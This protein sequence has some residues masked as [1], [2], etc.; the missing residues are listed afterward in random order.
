MSYFSTINHNLAIISYISWRLFVSFHCEEVG[1]TGL[2]LKKDVTMI[3]TILIVIL[4]LLLL[5][6]K[7]Y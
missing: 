3:H 1:G 2:A 7:A 4:L 5:V 6:T